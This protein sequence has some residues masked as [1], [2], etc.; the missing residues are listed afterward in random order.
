VFLWWTKQIDL[1][2]VKILISQ[3]NNGRRQQYCIYSCI[4]LY[5]YFCYTCMDFA[6]LEL[7]IK[8]YIQW[9][10]LHIF[11]LYTLKC[12]IFLDVCGSENFHWIQISIEVRVSLISLIQLFKNV[13]HAGVFT[14][15]FLLTRRTLD[16]W[17][18]NY[19]MLYN[20][21]KKNKNKIISFNKKSML[22]V[23]EVATIMF[24]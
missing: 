10:I 15:F 12:T 24:L 19:N 14:F 8:L 17:S 20:H 1:H 21:Y 7:F 4:L 2:V 6:P 5:V 9:E 16:A 11:L 13:M 3:N 23:K 22:K 18:T